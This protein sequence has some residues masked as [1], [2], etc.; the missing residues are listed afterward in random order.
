MKVPNTEENLSKCVCGGCPTFHFNLLEG[1]FFCAL[2]SFSKA[3]DRK[4]CNC[5]ACPAFTKYSLERGY[6]CIWGAAREW[7]N[8][9]YILW[10]D[11]IEWQLQTLLRTWENVSVIKVRVLHIKRII[12]A[13]G[14]FVQQLLANN[15]YN[16]KDVRV[17][18]VW[19][20]MNIAF[21][22]YI[23]VLKGLKLDN[24]FPQQGFDISSWSVGRTQYVLTHLVSMSFSYLT[25]RTNFELVVWQTGS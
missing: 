10:G 18:T 15:L 23:F 8:L 4:G 11:L 7:P 19:Y 22:N 12:W 6:F 21:R 13:E 2:S 16:E 1:G 14:S 3:S 20:G 24:F 25:R 17:T 5:P 9:C